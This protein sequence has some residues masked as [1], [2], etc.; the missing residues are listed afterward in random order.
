MASITITANATINERSVEINEDT[1]KVFNFNNFTKTIT[2]E[3]DKATKVE[4]TCKYVEILNGYIN[5][6][7]FIRYNSRKWVCFISIDN[8][9]YYFYNNKNEKDID[10]VNHISFSNVTKIFKDGKEVSFDATIGTTISTF[11]DGGGGGSEVEM[12][13]IINSL[14]SDSTI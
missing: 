8:D 7:M 13:Q 5:E 10:N 14:K 6:R 3:T 9:L 12:Y 4:H 11:F 1:I 2:L